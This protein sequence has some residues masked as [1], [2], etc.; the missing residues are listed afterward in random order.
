MGFS[1]TCILLSLDL[2]RGFIAGN[3]LNKYEYFNTLQI[4]IIAIKVDFVKQGLIY[5]FNLLLESITLTY[6]LNPS[7]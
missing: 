6:H 2:M 3:K 4:Y 7:P 5:Y 1:Y